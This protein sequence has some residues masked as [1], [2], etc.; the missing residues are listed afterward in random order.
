[1]EVETL[2]DYWKHCDLLSVTRKR[3]FFTLAF[4]RARTICEQREEFGNLSREGE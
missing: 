4:F 2:A 1:M 3:T